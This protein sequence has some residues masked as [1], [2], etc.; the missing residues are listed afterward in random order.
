MQFSLEITFG[1]YMLKKVA[2]A[3]KSFNC[4]V[5]ASAI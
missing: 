5:L 3:Y 2:V 4:L 1:I